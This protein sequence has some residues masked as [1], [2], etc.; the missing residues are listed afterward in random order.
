M[1]GWETW[2]DGILRRV[3]YVGDRDGDSLCV[4]DI[5]AETIGHNTG[6]IIIKLFLELYLDPS[7]CFL[8]CVI[9]AVR[10]SSESLFV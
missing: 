9:I 1:A 7:S 3:R 6:S 10:F 4:V 8:H 5:R 2:L